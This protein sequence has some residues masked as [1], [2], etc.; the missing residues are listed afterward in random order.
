MR[1]LAG[2]EVEVITADVI[3]RGVLVEIGETEIYLQS[4]S[5]WIMIPVEK[6]SEV[7]AIE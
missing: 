4:E 7:R 3:Y 1:E 2:K 5:G 6:V